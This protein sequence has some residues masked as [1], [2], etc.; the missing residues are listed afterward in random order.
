MGFEINE[1]TTK[2]EIGTLRSSRGSEI[3]QEDLC[4][5]VGGRASMKN[6]ETIDFT[7]PYCGQVLKVRDSRDASRHCNQDCPNSPY[8]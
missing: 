1:P 3:A 7:C 8:R 4:D 5:V 2:K 6:I